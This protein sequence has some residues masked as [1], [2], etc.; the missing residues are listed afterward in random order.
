MKT[1]QS[2]APEYSPAPALRP[3]KGTGR[4]F[5]RRMV[6]VYT[7]IVTIPLSIAILIGMERFWNLEYH[8]II[9]AAEADLKENAAHVS[10]CIELFMRFESAVIGNRS[11]DD[12]FLFTDKTDKAALIFQIWD[13]CG[14][15]ER[16]QFASPQVSIRIFVDDPAIPERW[17]VLFHR[18]RLQEPSLG[19]SGPRWR[20]GYPAEILKTAEGVMVSYTA[21]MLLRKRRIGELQ[22]LMPMADFFPFLERRDERRY[23]VFSIGES[24]ELSLGE[25]R[26]KSLGRP[27][28]EELLQAARKR[29][30]GVLKI[31]DGAKLR[32]IL[33]RGIPNTELILARDCGGELRGAGINSLRI[34]AGT[35]VVLSSILLFLFI[36]FVTG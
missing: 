18:E 24:R 32:Y 8:R 34:A 11:M 27:V 2:A 19:S 14:E 33:W 4:I 16:L 12:L 7:L 17:P 15:L 9:T 36:R 6:L 26:E 30:S 1:T 25:N 5:S 29:E 28:I 21:G 13:L 35:G 10:R 23:A 20:Y 31:R 22:L 3:G